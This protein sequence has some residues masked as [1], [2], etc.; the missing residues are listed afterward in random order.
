[1]RNTAN[2]LY[3]TSA[4]LI[5]VTAVAWGINAADAYISGVDVNSLDEALAE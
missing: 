2:S 1:M 4:V 3:A 5:G